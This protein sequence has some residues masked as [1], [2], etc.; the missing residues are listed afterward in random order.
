MIDTPGS[1]CKAC[2]QGDCYNHRHEYWAGNGILKS[3]R[4]PDPS[5]H[6]GK[7][8]PLA[9]PLALCA[10]CSAALTSTDVQVGVCT[11]CGAKV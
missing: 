2:A 3:C 7:L 10:A 4:C 5:G 11:Q 1:F 9:K 8:K 6:H